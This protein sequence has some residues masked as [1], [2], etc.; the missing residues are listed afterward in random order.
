MNPVM[1]A[2]ETARTAELDKRLA[3]RELE[4]RRREIAAGNVV[5]A[6]LHLP[7][8]AP[9]D[10]SDWEPFETWAKAK[11]LRSVPSRPSTVAFFVLDSAKLGIDRLLRIIGAISSTHAWLADPTLGPVVASALAQVSPPIPPP[12]SWP[13]PMRAKWPELPISLQQSIATRETARDKEVRR[14]Q[15]EAGD[16]KQ[17]L[18]KLKESHGRPQ[19]VTEPAQPAAS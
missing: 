9:A 19:T 13:A 5:N 15:N 2:L 17:A 18:A 8:V 4:M 1:Q 3:E 7:V 11:G 12:R 16:A 14:A 10:P 6:R